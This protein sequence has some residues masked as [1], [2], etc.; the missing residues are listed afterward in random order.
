MNTPNVACII[1]TML[2]TA[3]KLKL[4]KIIKFKIYELFMTSA[5]VLLFC[6]VKKKR[7]NFYEIILKYD[8]LFNPSWSDLTGR[9][10]HENIF[11]G[12]VEMVRESG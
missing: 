1:I 3:V 5:F 10:I 8:C 6:F 7:N 4:T 2:E 11:L 12:G 9:N